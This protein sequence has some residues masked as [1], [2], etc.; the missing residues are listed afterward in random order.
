MLL[1]Q[2]GQ[3]TI[4]ILIVTDRKAEVERDF[5]TK[6]LRGGQFGFQSFIFQDQGSSQALGDHLTPLSLFCR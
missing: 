4:I 6:V 3:N 1:T 2:F 5:V